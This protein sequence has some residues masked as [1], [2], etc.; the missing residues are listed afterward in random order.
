M[1]YSSLVIETDFDKVKDKD[2]IKKINDYQYA[3]DG[4]KK[5]KVY[6]TKVSLPL[7]T[8][9]F[10]DT[11]IQCSNKKNNIYTFVDA[12]PSQKNILSSASSDL[13]K[14]SE[15]SIE[16]PNF[17]TTTCTKKPVKRTTV[18]LSGKSTKK[19]H[20]VGIETFDTPSLQDMNMGQQFFIGSF[21][22]LGL[23]LFYKG[24]SRNYLRT[25]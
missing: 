24:L 21:A 5:T 18:S 20:Y 10:A 11:G 2:V 13:S 25:Q 8:K 22:V 17:K 1:N 19:S 7:G 6:N 16:N 12:K 15:D 14:I 3:F 23:F 4:N 9:Y